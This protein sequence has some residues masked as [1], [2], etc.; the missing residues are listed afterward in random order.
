MSKSLGNVVD[1][2]M[3]A[4]KYTRDGLRYFLLRE[5]VPSA[6][7]SIN[8][9]LFTKYINAELSNTL[10]NLYQRLL[11]FNKDMV[12][13]RYQEIESSLTTADKEFLQQ[14]DRLR[15]ECDQ[16]FEKFNFYDG[17]QLIMG[18]LRTANG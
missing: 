9:N 17:I 3:C 2:F 11:P 5:G 14:L 13:P 10:G 15:V 7:C 8:M 1:P 4:E 6:D 16:H 18:A 12:Y